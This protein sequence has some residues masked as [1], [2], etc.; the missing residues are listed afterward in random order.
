VFSMLRKITSTRR[1]L[2]VSITIF[3]CA[4]CASCADTHGIAPQTQPLAAS[5]IDQGEALRTASRNAA[6][7]S[8]AWWRDLHDPQLNQLIAVA[9]QDSPTL[10]VAAAR[11]REA[12]ALAQQARANTLPQL[13]L[14]ASVAR[15]RWPDNYFY[16]PGALAG[17]TTWNNTATLGLSYDPDLFGRDKD[18]ARRGLDV[19]HAAAADQRAAQL[20]LETNIIRTYVE[21]SLN[22]ALRD[23]LSAILGEQTHIVDIANKRLSG[24][25]GTQLDVSQAQV[26]L[27]E[28]RRQIE[29][30]D[31]NRALSRNELAILMGK[32]PGAADGLQ[33]PSLIDVVQN[34]G[35]PALPANLSLD[36]LGHRPDVVAQRW[37]VEAQS[38]GIAAAKAAFYP[39]VNLLVT[40]GGFAA[41][42]GPIGGGLLTFLAAKSLGYTAGPALSLP[43]FDGGRLRAQLGAASANYDVA[44][45]Q[46]DQTVL[47]AFKQ[48][49][50]QIVT[51]D[52]LA[53]QRT[54]IDE[55]LTIAQKNDRIAT[56]G[57]RRG[58]TDYLNVL[59]AQTRLLTEQQAQQRL[60][61]SQLDA[62]ATLM[63]A[64]GGGL[65]PENPNTAPSDV[66]AM[67]RAVP[68]AVTP[69][70]SPAASALVSP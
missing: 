11:T 56:E 59:D 20:T 37:M 24:G 52:S 2:T 38:Q 40:A 49:S 62:Y 10:A 7:P 5:Q 63:S 57:F 66:A 43:I 60:V 27:P 16:G 45:A 8:D 26:L 6:W 4:V 21:F 22:F 50:D 28:T 48:V 44:V 47:N 3:G 70:V 68:P 1:F 67:P 51:L 53:R 30:L 14:A 13:S 69:A 46:Y 15:D 23:K 39:D 36:L 35:A 42:G 17:A 54:Q 12:T 32:G 64:L 33:R 61:A 55:S 31:E 34:G 58:L 19:A 41:A 29:V 9:L 25:I 65:P 18:L